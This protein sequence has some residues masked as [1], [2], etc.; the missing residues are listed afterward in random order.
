MGNERRGFSRMGN[1]ESE[2]KGVLGAWQGTRWRKGPKEEAASR[3]FTT[4]AWQEG[5]VTPARSRFL[6][7]VLFIWDVRRV[8]AVDGVSPSSRA[9]RAYANEWR[10]VF[11][12]PL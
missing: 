1:G 10:S 6:R 3:S 8:R 4:G 9:I 11:S 5:A 12:L 2:S 7:R